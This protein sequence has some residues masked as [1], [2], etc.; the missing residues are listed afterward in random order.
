MCDRFPFP[1]RNLDVFRVA[2]ELATVAKRVADGVPH[3]YRKYRDQLL[4]AGGAPACLIAEGVNRRQKGVKRQR[5]EEARGECGEAAAIAELL[6]AMELAAGEDLERL[7]AL[8][9]R[10]GV[11]GAAGPRGASPGLGCGVRCSRR[12]GRH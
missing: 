11:R 1:H 6:A 9:G 7:D 8:A 3:G 10:V 12:R 2:V 5:Y 4:R